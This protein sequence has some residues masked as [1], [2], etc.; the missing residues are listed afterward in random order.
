MNGQHHYEIKLKKDDL[1]INLSS[2]DVYFISKQ[3]DKWFRILMDD[4]YVPVSLPV[5]PEPPPMAAPAFVTPL[6]NPPIEA[7]VYVQ[8]EPVPAPVPAAPVLEAQVPLPPVIQTQQPEALTPATVVQPTVSQYASVDLPISQ[9]PGLPAPQPA[10]VAAVPQPAAELTAPVIT[11]PL[12]QAVVP[13]EVQLVAPQTLPEPAISLDKPIQDDFEAVMDSLMHDLDDA[14]PVLSAA[15]E[16]PVNGNRLVTEPD[17]SMVSALS[18]LCEMSHASNS[19]D[20]LLLSA[21]YLIRFEHQHAFSLKNINSALVKSG[22]TPINHSI[23]ESVLSSGY[24][25]MVPDLTGTAEVTEYILTP[26]G[27]QVAILLFD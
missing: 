6:A 8:P 1:F 27:Q 12:P 18:D 21:F 16:Q 20:Y 23:L 14:E 22:L 5:R 25:A 11:P 4:S 2:D 19:E 7:P 10:I 17:F 3:M 15:Y 24:L 9:Q 13:P 26:E